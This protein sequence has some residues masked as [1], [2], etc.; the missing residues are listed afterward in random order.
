MIREE[1]QILR[2]KLKAAL[3]AGGGQSPASVSIRTRL[4]D[5]A[6]WKSASVIYGFAPLALEPD[7]LGEGAEGKTLAFP[8]ME[9]DALQFFT[10][11]TLETGP[12][13]VRQPT[14]G[15]PAPPPD[16][17]LVPGL[18]FDP[19]GFRL[20][21]GGGFY[22]RWLAANRGIKT[23]GICFACQLVEKI[24]VEA[25]DAQVDAVLTEDGLVHGRFG[26]TAPTPD[27]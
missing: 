11:G 27:W 2:K 14:G 4:R 18:G 19:A 20:G 6:G 22:D 21:R 25:H 10:G 3:A 26:T 13:G 16:L 12:F 5:V 17:V 15:S 1:K 23:L 7:W 8:R 9:N 24:P